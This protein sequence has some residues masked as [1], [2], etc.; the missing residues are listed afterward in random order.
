MWIQEY[1]SFHLSE[2]I[3][4]HLKIL[5]RW[6]QREENDEKKEMSVLAS[7]YSCERFGE[8]YATA[9]NIPVL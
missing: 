8:R 3:L 5:C 1:F 6:E 9:K 4:A 7:V 2:L